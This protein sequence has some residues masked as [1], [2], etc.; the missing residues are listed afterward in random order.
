MTNRKTAIT[1]QLKHRLDADLYQAVAARA[2]AE[3]RSLSNLVEVALLT[4]LDR[5]PPPVI[6]L[7]HGLGDERMGRST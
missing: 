1:R 2:E 4:Y 7:R 3:H 6:E 5:E